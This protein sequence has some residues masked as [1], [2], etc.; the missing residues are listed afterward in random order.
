MRVAVQRLQQKRPNLTELHPFAPAK[1]IPTRSLTLG[2]RVLHT[3]TSVFDRSQDPVPTPSYSLAVASH[4]L[5]ISP[6][7]AIHDIGHDLTHYSAWAHYERAPADKTEHI[8]NSFRH[9]GRRR[10]TSHDIAFSVSWVAPGAVERPSFFASTEATA[11]SRTSPTHHVLSHDP[12]QHTISTLSTDLPNPSSAATPSPQ[13]APTKTQAPPDQESEAIAA[14]ML[15]TMTASTT[16]I[17]EPPLT[18]HAPNGFDDVADNGSSSLSELGDA[19]DDQSEP[20][21]RPTTRLDEDDSEAETERLENTPRKIARADTETSLL[22][23]PAYTRTP[24]KLAHSKTIEQD[25][26]APATPSGIAEDVTMGDADAAENPLHSL[27]LIAASEAA[28]LEYLGKERKRASPDRSIQ[29]EQEE[30]PLRKRSKTAKSSALD[31]LADAAANRQGQMDA[32]EE[33]NHAE[34]H[35]S[36]LARE[37]HKL[38]ERQANIAAQTVNEMATVAKHT[39]PRKGG[40]RGKRKTEDASYAYA[41]PFAATEAHEPEAEGEHDEE[42]SALMDEEV[43][44]KKMAIDELNKIEKKFKLFREKLCDEQI[45]QLE[46]ELE[47]LKQPNCVHPEYVAMIKC[48]DDRRADKIAYET[49]LLEYKQKNLD[50]ITTAERHQLHSQFFQTVR[51]V[52]EEILEDCNQRVFELQR[53]RRQLGC[54]ETN[55][56]VKLPGKRSDQIRHQAAYNLEVS[57]L[58]GV[59]KYVGFPA[60]PDISAARPSEIDDDLRA[61]K[62]AT[63][64]PVPPPSFRTYNRTTTADEVAAEEQ[65]IESTPWANP[66]HPSHQEGRYPPGPSRL[67]S[68]QTPAGQRRMVDLTAPNGSASTIEANSNPP[69]SNTHNHGMLGDADSPVMQMKRASDHSNYADGPGSDPRNMSVLSRETYGMMSSPAAQHMDIPHEQGGPRWVGNNMRPLNAGSNPP[70][71]SG[72]PGAGSRPDAARPPLP[73]RSGLG[74]IS[75]GSGLFGR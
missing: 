21:P 29:D 14:T 30:E 8:T 44:K 24:S 54:D 62:I 16:V 25:D 36:A 7:T 72:P 75:V 33:L 57:V 34:E 46:R 37:E 41:E 50:I 49:T 69:S 10:A 18:D 56:M 20:T 4:A 52:R 6:A 31:G 64:V 65:F 51:H 59:A 15:S 61:M 39:K 55:Y 26:S 73:Q 43:T 19:S 68:Y 22:S 27:S 47:M 58:S 11:E 67:P 66:R 1:F 23:E 28:N 74:T 70:P 38:E 40:R 13:S 63:R 32:E 53:G 60:A 35:L 42:D 5:S 2:A 12:S 45:A 17:T 3:S 71:P 48:I 9:R